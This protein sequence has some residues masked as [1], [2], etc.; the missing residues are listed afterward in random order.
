M[1]ENG[2]NSVLSSYRCYFVHFSQGGNRYNDFETTLF[3]G[4]IDK[5]DGY[6]PFQDGGW[7]YHQ[8]NG[9]NIY[10]IFLEVYKFSHNTKS[11]ILVKHDSL[12]SGVFYRN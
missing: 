10:C 1:I 5:W 3:H 2:G 4:C 6:M 8:N 9:Q 7:Y 12:S 11:K